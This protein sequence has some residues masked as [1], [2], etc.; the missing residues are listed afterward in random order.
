M[1]SRKIII[2]AQTPP[3]FHGQAIMQKYLVD[4]NWNWCRK[5]FVRMNFS[6]SIDE[7][8]TFKGKKIR[9]LFGLMN[10]I[11]KANK[12]KA[13]VI[14]Y[15]PSGPNRIGIYRDVVMLFFLKAFSRKI[16]LHFHAGGIDQIFDK[17]SRIESFFI[18]KAFSKPDAAIVLTKWLEKEVQWCKPEKTFVVENGIEDVTM[19]FSTAKRLQNEPVVFIFV[20]NLKKEKGVFTLLEA[21]ATLKEQG[22]KFEIKFVGAFHNSG[23]K[24]RFFTFINANALQGFVNYMGIR[25]GKEKW[26]EFGRA[27][28]F[29]LPTYETEAMPISILEA[30][31]FG[32]PVIT[33]KWRSIP[34][35]IHHQENGLLFEPTDAMSLASSMQQLIHSENERLRLGRQARNDYLKKFTVEQHLRKMENVFQE[36][37]N[38]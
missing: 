22:E 19:Q 15:P 11:R 4:V 1:R 31:M 25:S 14:Y 29:C 13:G 32:M 33:T 36:V 34:D 6:D 24:E 26:V 8:G 7:V 16:L 12:P 37:L 28:V 27:D 30:M 23:E 3:P 20:G 21:A 18:K 38:R 9:Q 5:E 10:S 17:V 2:I 35:I